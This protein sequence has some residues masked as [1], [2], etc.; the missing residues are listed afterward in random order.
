MFIVNFLKS[1]VLQVECRPFHLYL[2]LIK[3]FLWDYL[4]IPHQQ[5]YKIDHLI[6]L[7]IIYSLSFK[8]ITL[9]QGI[10]RW[11]TYICFLILLYRS[12]LKV[13]CGALMGL[14]IYRHF[15]WSTLRVHLLFILTHRPNRLSSPLSLDRIQ[16]SACACWVWWVNLPLS[17]IKSPALQ[18]TCHDPSIKN[19]VSF[20]FSYSLGLLCVFWYFLTKFTPLLCLRHWMF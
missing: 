19:F 8:K 15:N 5:N 7:F 3:C 14:I 20:A 17:L 18:S 6:H 1:F 2:I 16:F 12:F 4:V 9:N 13:T 11:L 10:W